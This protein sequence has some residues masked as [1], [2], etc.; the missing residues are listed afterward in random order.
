MHL[1]D[2]L[3]VFLKFKKPNIEKEI[4]ETIDEIT[5]IVE[6]TKET[7]ERARNKFGRFIADDPN[8]PENEAYKE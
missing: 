1:L 2:K 4:K 8:T 5:D 7:R 6:K 3:F